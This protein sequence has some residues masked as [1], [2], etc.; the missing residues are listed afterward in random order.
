MQGMDINAIKIFRIQSSK[1]IK[2]LYCFFF[3]EQDPM[4]KQTHLQ[5]NSVLFKYV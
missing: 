1:N 2:T 4:E 5:I 3:F